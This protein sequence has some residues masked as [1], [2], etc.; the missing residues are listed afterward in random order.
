MN[1]GPMMSSSELMEGTYVEVKHVKRWVVGEG[2]LVGIN[3]SLLNRKELPNYLPS[4]VLPSV[5]KRKSQ[6]NISTSKMNDV[7]LQCS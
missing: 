5:K 1:S 2:V 7:R 3:H 4:T 6:L